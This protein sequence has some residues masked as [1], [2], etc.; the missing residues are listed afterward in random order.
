MFTLDNH[1]KLIMWFVENKLF[2]SFPGGPTHQLVWYMISM[3]KKVESH[4]RG[5][6]GT[7][8]WPLRV[9]SACLGLGRPRGD[10]VWQRSGAGGRATSEEK[11]EAE[12]RRGRSGGRRR[13]QSGIR[14]CISRKMIYNNTSDFLWRRLITVADTRNNRCGIRAQYWC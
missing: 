1:G 4:T 8:A 6:S 12:Q 3:K 14:R 13:R 5:Q 10:R 9:G 2:F 7:T 11:E